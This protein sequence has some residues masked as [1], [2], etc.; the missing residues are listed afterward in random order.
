MDKVLIIFS[1]LLG[2]IVSVTFFPD[3]LTASL[4]AF[5]FSG[6][7]VWVLK[8]EKASFPFLLRIFL[9]ALLLRVIMATTIYGFDLQLFFGPDAGSY[10][11]LG[12]VL[13][14]EWMGNRVHLDPARYRAMSTGVGWGMSRIVASIYLLLGRNPL[15]VQF[16]SCVAGAA[17][18]PAIYYCA[19]RIFGNLKVA[20]RS[21]IIVALCPSLIIWSSQL[22]KDGFII[23]LIVMITVSVLQLQVR[24]NYWA[25][26]VLIFSLL[27]VL[28]LRFYIFYIVAVSALGSFL[29]GAWNTPQAVFRRVLVILAVGLGL[30]ALGVFQN[31]QSDIETYTNLDRI[32]VSRSGLAT[33]AGSGY[34][35]DINVSTANGVLAALPI[36][37]V[38]LMFAPFPWQVA[39]LRQLLTLPE[40]LV[41]WGSMPL[42]LIGI[43]YTIR[44]RFRPSIVILLFTFLLTIS[45]SIYLGNI[46]TAYRQRAQIQVFLII[47]I[48]VGW[49]L[50]DEKRED[51]A[52]LRRPV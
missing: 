8:Q 3:G 15:A 18:V 41:W 10:D 50:I 24:A 47:L 39:N 21:A 31:A 43:W 33:T 16:L 2:F 28:S 7:C 5:I 25:I 38:Y 27:G 42:L 19:H 6:L 29:I 34:G 46:G 11:T 12:Y 17:T 26:A 45:Y 37:F 9:I 32:Q 22:L 20:K 40:T 48:S 49:T 23:F 51:K 30:T 1:C 4:V 36:G 44:N 52:R 35:A 13:S 14:E